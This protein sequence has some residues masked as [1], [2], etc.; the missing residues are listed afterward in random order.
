MVRPQ[1]HQLMEP[2]LKG[3]FFI[4]KNTFCSCVPPSICIK[5][6]K[7]LVFLFAVGK[8]VVKVQVKGAKEI[9]RM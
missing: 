4:V 7:V 3:K 2:L 5:L 1:E 9:L 8:A 6:L